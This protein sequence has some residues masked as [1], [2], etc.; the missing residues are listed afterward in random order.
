[1]PKVHPEDEAHPLLSPSKQRESSAGTLLQRRDSSK[2]IS[3]SGSSSSSSSNSNSHTGSS[4]PSSS[5]SSSSISVSTHADS[6]DSFFD[7]SVDGEVFRPCQICLT[8]NAILINQPCNHQTLCETCY[9]DQRSEN[10]EVFCPLCL[11]QITKTRVSRTDAKKYV[12]EASVAV[13][14]AARLE[15]LASTKLQK[16]LLGN[17]L[18]SV[19]D[20]DVTPGIFE[21]PEPA[22]GTCFGPGVQL[23]FYQT[24]MLVIGFFLLSCCSAPYFLSY[25]QALPRSDQVGSADLKRLIVLDFTLAACFYVKECD[26]PWWTPAIDSFGVVLLFLISRRVRCVARRAVRNALANHAEA[27]VASR[28]VALVQPRHVDAMPTPHNLAPREL[29]PKRL[30]FASKDVVS[31]PSEEQPLPRMKI[32]GCGMRNVLYTCALDERLRLYN[33]LGAMEQLIKVRQSETKQFARAKK[34]AESLR[35]RIQKL[36]RTVFERMLEEEELGA[37]TRLSPPVQLLFVLFR[38][39]LDAETLR[40]RVAGGHLTSLKLVFGAPESRFALLGSRRGGDIFPG[41]IDWPCLVYPHRF[42]Q[43]G[44]P[45]VFGLVALIVTGIVLVMVWQLLQRLVAIQ[46]DHALIGI[47]IGIAVAQLACAQPI[48]YAL[49]KFYRSPLKSR[50]EEHS[51]LII[52]FAVYVSSIISLAIGAGI[53][54]TQ[55]WWT[56]SMCE[57]SLVLSAFAL[58]H[59]IFYAWLFRTNLLPAIRSC[60]PI[61]TVGYSQAGLNYR[62]APPKWSV[63]NAHLDVIRVVL[64]A[65]LFSGVVHAAAFL[66]FFTLSVIYLYRKSMLVRLCQ[67][68]VK[69]LG[70]ACVSLTAD[71]LEVAL[72]LRL[73]STAAAWWILFPDKYECLIPLGSCAVLCYYYLHFKLGLCKLYKAILIK[74]TWI[75]HTGCF[76]KAAKRRAA[77]RMK[78]REFRRQRESKKVEAQVFGKLSAENIE[79][80]DSDIMRHF[81]VT[82]S[83]RFRLF[84]EHVHTIKNLD[85]WTIRQVHKGRC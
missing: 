50:Q 63:S 19:E 62:L 22:I 7:F 6:V 33:N 40:R 67:V 28:C 3:R 44:T 11:R 38:R 49:R 47:G 82:Q 45:P 57:I 56:D 81:D 26:I 85:K 58:L 55:E 80:L 72:L 75:C 27:K 13:A 60:S 41:N 43:S 36:D 14:K 79:E 35:T 65:T 68:Q 25:M 59:A 39:P 4:S 16:E 21:V 9:D 37:V 84:F 61:V 73:L 23:F 69:Y 83:R 31:H 54:F 30:R 51:L 2:Q 53:P 18:A 1:M 32:V 76:P 8:E 34:S 29:G 20:T 70:N 66:C 77:R 42:A 52:T 78:K 10:A 64:T 24:R 74:L 12:R 15:S 5:A 46:L 17:K 71:V 48:R